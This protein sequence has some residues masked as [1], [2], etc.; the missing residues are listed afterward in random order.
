MQ[1]KKYKIFGLFLLVFP[2]LLFSQTYTVEVKEILVN[3]TIINSEAYNTM[4][5]TTR[6]PITIS[7]LDSLTFKY[8]IS[9]KSPKVT[10]PFFF[11]AVLVNNG[12]SSARTSGVKEIT[13]CNLQEGNY[14]FEINAFDLSGDWV[15]QTERI[16]FVVNNKEADLIKLIGKLKQEFNAADSTSKNLRQELDNTKKGQEFDK[17]LEIASAVVIIAII[18]I[19]GLQ[20]RKHKNQNKKI[21][22]ELGNTNN[23]FQHFDTKSNN[24]NTKQ[25]E[26][27]TYLKQKMEL[28]SQKME[29][30]SLLNEGIISDVN[31]VTLKNNQLDNLHKQR[32]VMFADIVKGINNP[33]LAIKGLVDLLRNYD[34]NAYEMKDIVEN[35]VEDTKKI[36]NLSEDIQR[37]GEFES[38]NFSLNFDTT[39]VSILVKNAIQQNENEAKRKKINLS[40]NVADDVVPLVLDPLKITVVLNNLIDNA[41]KFTDEN[42]KVTVNCFNKNNEVCFDII[43]TGIGIDKSDL[44]KL[45]EN[46]QSENA[47]FVNETTKIGLLTV[48]KYVEAHDGKVIVSSIL[49]KGSTF[50]FSIPYNS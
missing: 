49:G 13:F 40:Y 35:I 4:L 42:G 32:N 41:I 20:I 2:N 38:D 18:I 10:K 5:T 3:N 26:E 9:E 37:L 16:N 27:I 17:L 36:I 34:F 19:F 39:D 28:I 29:D 30:I 31:T 7:N 47:I 44:Q 50:S 11:H 46:L 15:S 45:Y 48:K 43:D 21:M 23:T 8:E 14:T 1:M 33:T 22:L 6:T 12:A 25:N 24:E